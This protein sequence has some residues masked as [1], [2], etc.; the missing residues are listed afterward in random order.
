MFDDSLLL[1]FGMARITE[2]KDYYTTAE[3]K[4]PGKFYIL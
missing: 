2:E 4:L 3:K 1:D